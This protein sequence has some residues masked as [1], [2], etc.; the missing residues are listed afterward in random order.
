[1]TDFFAGAGYF[2]RG[3][4]WTARRPRQWLFGLIPAVIVM[5]VYIVGLT[6][7]GVYGADLARTLS[8]FA[9][10][11]SSGLRDTTRVLIVI[12][13][14]G[15]AVMIAIVTFV[16]VTLVVGAPFYESI[17]GKV[18]E[19]VGGLPP[20]ADVPLL[21]Q[22][23]R[24]IGDA[25]VVGLM[26]TLFAVLFFF[27]G[28]IP[29]VGQ[30]VIPVLG[31]CVSGY[32]LTFEAT[33]MAFERR[34][35]RRKERFV[36]MRRNR[37]LSVGFGVTVFVVFLIPFGAILTMPGAVAGGTLLMRERL[38]DHD[39]SARQEGFDGRVRS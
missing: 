14:F 10:H 7:L 19:S 8:P 11:W 1:M 25:I 29:V 36:L 37:T 12:L 30:T 22:L 18:E 20:E 9:D 23:M 15:A 26:A 5:V 34:G 27:L 39:V 33:S 28:F 21:T 4:A 3:L 32:F 2:T 24:G 6:S 13:L 35:V 17:A 31:A 16:G 38:S